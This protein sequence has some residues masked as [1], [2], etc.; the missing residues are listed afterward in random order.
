MENG[1]ILTAIC[2]TIAPK[3]KLIINAKI[4]FQKPNSIEI[5]MGGPIRNNKLHKLWC[6]FINKI[7]IKMIQSNITT[8][9]LRKTVTMSILIGEKSNIAIIS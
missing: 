6:H 8:Y 9:I 1:I 2:P 5:K 4:P 3:I 7:F